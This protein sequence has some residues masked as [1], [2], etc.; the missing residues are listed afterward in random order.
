MLEQSYNNNELNKTTE[1]TKR[2]FSEGNTLSF[3]FLL[4]SAKWNKSLPLNPPHKAGI[5]C[6]LKVFSHLCHILS[7]PKKFKNARKYSLNC[8]LNTT[9]ITKG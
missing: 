1:I 3:Q 4:E 5:Q 8:S 6:F 7:P 2:D 9:W